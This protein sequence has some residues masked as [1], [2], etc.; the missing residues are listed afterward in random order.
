METDHNNNNTKPLV[1][2]GEYFDYWKDRLQSFF[3]G[4]GPDLQ[5]MD[6]YGYIHPVDKEGNKIDRKTMDKQHKA[7][8][9]NH[10][11][12]KNILLNAISKMEYEKITNRDTA[13]DIFESLKMSHEGNSQVKETKALAIIQKYG[14]F[15]IEENES[16]ETM[17]SRF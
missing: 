6:L 8:F 5:D 11:K 4:Y 12:A 9:K 3:L 7:D 17:F 1:F 14:A 13:H 10:H 16:I 15:R 2:D